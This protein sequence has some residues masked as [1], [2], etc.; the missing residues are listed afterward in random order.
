MK[1]SD[2]ICRK[3]GKS[4]ADCGSWLRLIKGTDQWE[5]AQP[6]DGKSLTNEEKLLGA[7]EDDK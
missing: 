6:C 3:C 1:V 5:C 2:V 7:I 4:A